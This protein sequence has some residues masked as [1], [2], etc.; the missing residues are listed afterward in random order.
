[1]A[2][3]WEPQ[4]IEVYKEWIDAIVNEASDDLNVWETSFLDSLGDRLASG[5][6]L[7]EAQANKLETMYSEKTK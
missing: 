4:P 6:N 1:M 2:K 5:R 7:S 3:I